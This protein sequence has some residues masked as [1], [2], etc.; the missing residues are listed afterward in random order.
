MDAGFFRIMRW[1][2]VAAF[3]ETRYIGKPLSFLPVFSI[4]GRQYPSPF[5]CLLYSVPGT[6]SY[7]TEQAFGVQ[8]GLLLY[9]TRFQRHSVQKTGSCG[10]EE[11]FGAK[12]RLLRYATH[13]RCANSFQYNT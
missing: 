1:I 10:T 13:L 8:K 7:G 9:A 3:S 2:H 6:P 12:K 5:R 4:R 11:I